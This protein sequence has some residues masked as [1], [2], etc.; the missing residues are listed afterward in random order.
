MPMLS[1]LL[2]AAL[3]ALLLANSVHIAAQECPNILLIL[4]DD[5]GYGDASSYDSPDVETPF[6][7]QLGREGVRF[8][9]FRVNPLCAPT[10]ASILSGLYSLESGMW[11]GPANPGQNRELRPRALKARV[12]L[13][14]E[15]LREAG[16]ATGL[17]GKWHLGYE[18]PNLPNDRGFDEFVGFL[19]GSHPYHPSARSRLQHNGEPLG[20]TAHT[21]DLFADAAIKFI[22]EG[23]DS[24]FFCYVAFNAVHGPL[25]TKK[26][27]KPSA[28]SE[29]LATYEAKGAD[30][31]RRDYNAVLGHMDDRVGDILATLDATGASDNTLVIYLSDNGA[32]IDKFPG[33]NGPLRG[34]KAFTY[35]G[36][37]RVPAV[38]RW[39]GVIPANTVSEA[40]AAHFDLF[41]TILDAARVEPPEHN[42][43]YPIR[44]LSLL[45]H[46]RSGAETPLAER[47]LFWDLFGRV[48]AARGPWKLVKQTPN[49]R[50]DF[51]KAANAIRE[52]Q[53][54][55][56]DLTADLGETNDLAAKEPRVYE[57]LRAA[58]IDWL[59]E[60]EA[61]Y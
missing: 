53:L 44:G 34:A 25:W 16:Y 47:T 52:S 42:G 38:M 54:E 4:S 40:Y 3:A 27:P 49:H 48:A 5:Q 32:I 41:A 8:T 11:R 59:L 35:E 17:F 46:L 29:W 19:G 58:L 22:E 15:L 10:R 45:D 55:L 33:D 56:Y 28:T 51:T 36:G 23:R 57:E 31:P 61:N 13:L 24:P 1:P 26:T 37:I 21:T 18:S 39:P 14:P 30:L 9:A 50:G 60:T 6:M 7:D 43:G 12:R 2:R 20:T